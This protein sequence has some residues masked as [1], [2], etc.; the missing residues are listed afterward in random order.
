MTPKELAQEKMSKITGIREQQFAEMGES[1]YDSLVRSKQ[2]AVLPEQIFVEYFLPYFS[3]QIPLTKD[4]D[5]I[6]KWIAIAGSPVG[7]VD[8]IGNAN[9]VLFTVP[10]YMNT[11]TINPVRQNNSISILSHKTRHDMRKINLPQVAEVEFDRA[12]VS[13][14]NEFTVTSETTTT[15]SKRWSDIM[16]RYGLIS[17]TEEHQAPVPENEVEDDLIYD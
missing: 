10:P 16:A 17:T 6:A 4:D 2:N 12:L 15:I 5:V 1:L 11:N 9:N 8:I 13:K 3:H 14:T 7:E